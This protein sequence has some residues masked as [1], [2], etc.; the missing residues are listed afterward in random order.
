MKPADPHA[1]VMGSPDRN[2]ARQSVKEHLERLV[3]TGT[4]LTREAARHRGPTIE[5]VLNNQALF[6][7]SEDLREL[8]RLKPVAEL[9]QETAPETA[10]RHGFELAG[11]CLVLVK[12]VDEGRVFPLPPPATGDR[13]WVVGRRRSADVSLD[14]DPFASS[15]SAVVLAEGG[16]FF[17]EDVVDS[18]NGTT[19]NLQPLPRGGR[20]PLRN[21]DIVGVG[22]SL[23][24]F[25]A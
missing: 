12:G 8:A 15:D 2:L 19:L 3:A 10:P 17:V 13:R 7:L 14:F 21:G 20:E 18:R 11:P 1:L 24:V 6:A 9:E 23:L 4:V 5:Y 25:R 22:R 16:R